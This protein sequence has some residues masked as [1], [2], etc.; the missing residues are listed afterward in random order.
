MYGLTYDLWD[1]I[2]KSIVHAYSELAQSMEK[3]ARG[4]KLS[5]SLVDE[6]KLNEALEIAEEPYRYMLSIEMHDDELGG[7]KISLLASE[8]LDDFEKKKVVA[9]KIHKISL[10]D[11]KNFEAEHGLDLTDEILGRL[12]DEYEME[13][14]STEDEIIFELVIFDSEDIDNNTRMS[15]RLSNDWSA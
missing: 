5:K 9:A 11:I 2:I 1:A 15:R 13:V 10:Q 7:F 8:S 6:L 4:I 3:T 14:G 12:E